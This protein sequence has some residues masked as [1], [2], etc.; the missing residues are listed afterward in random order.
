[1]LYP[2]SWT[3]YLCEKVDLLQELCDD[4]HDS[5]RRTVWQSSIRP[6]SSSRLRWRC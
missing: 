1:V 4:K 2:K 3:R 6:G 5:G